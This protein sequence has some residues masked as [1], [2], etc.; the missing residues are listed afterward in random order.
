MTKKHQIHNHNNDISPPDEEME[1]QE[2]LKQ[3]EK[4]DESESEDKEEDNDDMQWEIEDEEMIATGKGD[5]LKQLR[6]ELRETKKER[7]EYLA[8]WQKAKADYIN[9]RNEEEKKRSEL[10]EVF[11]EDVVY[12]LFPV[13]DSFEMAMKN[14]EVWESVDKNWR[15]GVEYI[16]QQLM[17]LLSHYGVTE[18]AET[19]IPFDPLIHEVMETEEGGEKVGQVI[20]KGYRKGE[21]IIRPAKVTLVQ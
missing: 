4:K 17:T 6:E 16:Y 5:K 14:K 12:D 11:R 2:T 10:R 1:G 21:R 7:D 20:Q 9:L 3:Q 15:V 8:G 13:L 18:I 19:S